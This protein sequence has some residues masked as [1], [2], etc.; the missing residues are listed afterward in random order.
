MLD[1]DLNKMRL[2]AEQISLEKRINN[3]KGCKWFLRLLEKAEQFK[4]TLE[5]CIKKFIVSVQQVIED[6]YEFT[7]DLFYDIHLHVLTYEDHK[8]A[9][10]EKVTEFVYSKSN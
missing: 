9:E 1:T 7:T 6:G 8:D 3:I 4:N 10:L 5:P 2:T